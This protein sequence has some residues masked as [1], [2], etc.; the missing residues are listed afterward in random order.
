MV[1][2]VSSVLNIPIEQTTS[3]YISHFAAARFVIS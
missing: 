2:L 3:L 1:Y